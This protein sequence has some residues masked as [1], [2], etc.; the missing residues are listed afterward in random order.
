MNQK[1]RI[2]VFGAMTLVTLVLVGWQTDPPRTKA[3][4][5]HPVLRSGSLD[6]L[7]QGSNDL[8]A[9]AGTCD[10]CHGLDPAGLASVD[11]MGNDVNVVDDWRSS[12]MANSARD[13]FWRAKV[14]HEVAVNP[15]L[16]EEIESTCTKCHAPMGRFEA[17]HN[18]FEHYSIEE[19]TQD[20]MALDGVSCLACHQQ[21]PQ[22]EVANHSGGLIFDTNRVA[23]GPYDS[24][25]VTPM[26][27]Y[28]EYI[29]EFGP[30]INDAKLC[31]GCHSLVT[32][33]V[34]LEGNL[35]GEE[36]VEQATWHE[37]L[38]SSFSADNSTCQTCHLPRL[39]KQ[40]VILAAGYDTEPR[41]PYGLHTLAGGNSLM[42]SIM[43]DYREVLG[44]SATE[45]QF[46][47]TIDATLEQLQQH[48]VTVQPTVLS[49]T[50]DTVFVSIRLNNLTGHKLPSGYPARRMSL[51]VIMRDQEGNEL[52][53]SGG[54]DPE[55]FTVGEDLPYEPH[56]QII[57]SQ[58]EVQIYEMV[59]G[60]VNN[61]RT[62]VL[63]RGAVHLKDNRLVPQGFSFS[64]PLYDTTEVVLNGVDDPDFN[65]V[66]AEG[67][68]A[69]IVYY[70]IP[71]EGFTGA[72]E[73]TAEV[74]YQA[75]PPNWMDEIFTVDTPEINTWQ[76]MYNAADRTPVLMRSAQ[77]DVP[78]FVNLHELNARGFT[79]TA[80][81]RDVRITAPQPGELSIY[82]ARGALLVRQTVTP[83]T[84]IIQ[85]PG[86]M[87]TCLVV[88]NGEVRKVLLTQ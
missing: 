44:I 58:N 67:S 36:F 87:G 66:P 7:F 41:E 9:T 82:D 68:G 21:L 64:H 23:Y 57:R 88:L 70:H 48:S 42:L 15:L 12:I 77:V 72:V 19:M 59:M 62:T 22:G 69:D 27:L 40:A 76:E 16:Q 51:H 6:S 50:E 37:W 14:S 55:F 86:A 61:N 29:P 84:R 8:F 49:R 34:D 63:E 26:A 2:A 56:H 74:Y 83:G 39:S 43:R 1:S 60:D 79:A 13:P 52:F 46:N 38:N 10:H 31:A 11:A 30:H 18:G 80:F 5:V 81:G 28:S 73:V 3:H 85:V 75:L 4:F 65:L 54:F 20:P 32:N 71:T 25:L 47:A 78:S 53:R 24:P 33:T 17:M 45:E 35:T